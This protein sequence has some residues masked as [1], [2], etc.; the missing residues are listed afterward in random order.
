MRIFIFLFVFLTLAKLSA[1]TLDIAVLQFP[2]KE[3]GRR[4]DRGALWSESSSNH[5]LQSH[6]D[7]E[8]V[9][10]GWICA[11]HAKPLPLPRNE[12]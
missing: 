2:G 9:S 3:D 6:H 5:R 8:A 11:F 1:G 7:Q 10:Q 12:F 4:T